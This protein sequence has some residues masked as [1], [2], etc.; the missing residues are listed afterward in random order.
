M[1]NL[2]KIKNVALI[3]EIEVEFSA[4]L[5]LLTGE[6]GSGKSIIVDS[7]GALSG[8][9]ISSDLIKEGET[10]ARIEGLF[11]LRSNKKL[12]ELLDEGGIE[13]DNSKEIEL[14]VRRELSSSGKNRVFVNNQLVTQN[15]LRSIGEFLL[16][17]HGQGEQASLYSPSTHLEMLDDFAGVRELRLRVADEFSLLNKTKTE[18]V[19]LRGDEAQKLQLVD[20]LK[21]QIAELAAANLQTGEDEKLEDEKRRLSN[22]EKLSTLSDESYSLLYDD[23]HAVIAA[24]E[25]ISKRINELSGY[26]SSFRDFNE[27]LNSAEANLNELAISIRDFRNRLEFSPERL[28]EIENRLAQISQLK[29]KYGGS[30]ESALAHFEDS[31]K[32]VRN[33]ET[34]DLREAELREQLTKR[35]GEYIALARELSERRKTAARKLEK[36]VV[37]NLQSVALEKSRFEVRIESPTGDELN[38]QDFAQFSARGFDNVEFY[39]SANVGESL[40]PIAKVASG[41][42]ASR[43]MLVLKTVATISHDDKAAVFDEVDVGIGGRVAEAVGLKLKELSKSQQVL[44]VTHQ[45]QVASLADQHFFVDKRV[46]KNRTE[47]FVRELKKEERVEEIARMLTGREITATARKHAK[48]MIAAAR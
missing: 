11:L 25:K 32:R 36:E 20:I 40:K 44:C 43:L 23:E 17:I 28:E 10:Q 1:L 5:N 21:F 45:P 13:T 2:L 42:E 3:S 12:L 6:T 26:E 9:R 14:I 18:L 30:I 47:I 46:S 15:F 31:E 22:V 24:L 33:I 38:D 4:G 48:E 7:L 37:K 39:F 35:R 8:T 19:N 29:R 16:D 27:A 34:A 41:G